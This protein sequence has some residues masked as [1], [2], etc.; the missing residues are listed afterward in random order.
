MD[1]HPNIWTKIQ[2]LKLKL[3]EWNS[4]TWTDTHAL[5]LTPKHLWWNSNTLGKTQTLGFTIIIS[6]VS[7]RHFKLM[8]SLIKDTQGE[9]YQQ[10][11]I[12]SI[13]HCLLTLGLKLEHFDWHQN[14]WTYIP[15]I[16]LKS[17]HLDWNSNTWTETQKLGLKLKNLN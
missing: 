1:W 4:N 8:V 6:G 16:G 2:I 13:I 5:K 9:N 15:T 10:Q 17:K 11:Y 7:Y 3:L 12:C 14:A